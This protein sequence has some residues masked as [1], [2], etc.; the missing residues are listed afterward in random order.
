MKITSW[1]PLFC[2]LL[3]DK[4]PRLLDATL[5]DSSPNIL[6]PVILKC[7][8]RLLVAVMKHPELWNKGFISP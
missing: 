6:K 1:N 7:C 4:S 5:C 2:K 3:Y 8:L